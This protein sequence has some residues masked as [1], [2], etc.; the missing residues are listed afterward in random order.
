MKTAQVIWIKLLAPILCVVVFAKREP[1]VKGWVISCLPR[2]TSIYIPFLAHSNIHIKQQSVKY[3]QPRECKELIVWGSW[4]LD[5]KSK[6]RRNLR[7]SSKIAETW[8]TFEVRG[9]KPWSNIENI[10]FVPKFKIYHFLSHWKFVLQ[11]RPGLWLV[12]LVYYGAL[13]GQLV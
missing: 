11:M 2:N 7:K 12:S 13:I 10:D 6:Q 4:E 5:K 3:I 1:G 8:L 9:V